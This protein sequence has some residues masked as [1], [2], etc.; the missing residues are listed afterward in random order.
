MSE[1]EFERLFPKPQDGFAGALERYTWLGQKEGY[2]EALKWA[3]EIVHSYARGTGI[4][5]I[6]QQEIE[7]N[8]Q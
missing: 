1:S 6:F 2:L 8:E 3:K 7:A 5:V 4:E